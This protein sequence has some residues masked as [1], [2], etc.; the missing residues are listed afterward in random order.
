LLFRRIRRWLAGSA[1]LGRARPCNR[2]QGPA[3]IVDELWEGGRQRVSPP[4]QNNVESRP[5]IGPGRDRDR[6][7]KATTDAVAFSCVTDALGHS[8]TDAQPSMCGFWQG[9]RDSIRVARH[10][11]LGLAAKTLHGHATCMKS[12]TC[13]NG[14][15]LGSLGQAVRAIAALDRRARD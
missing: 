3:E 4:H 6:S 14:E 9:F 10:Q 12:A 15:K 5:S 11:A 7:T 1:L 13:R 8:Q 2:R